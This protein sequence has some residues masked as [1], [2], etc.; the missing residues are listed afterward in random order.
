MRVAREN[1]KSLLSKAIWDD[2]VVIL[3]QRSGLLQTF[4]LLGKAGDGSVPHVRILQRFQNPRDDSW[5]WHVSLEL[6]V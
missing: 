4:K 6:H 2:H 3:N 5:T 1:F